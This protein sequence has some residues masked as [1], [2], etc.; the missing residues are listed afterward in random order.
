MCRDTN[1]IFVKSVIK[2]DEASYHEISFLHELR[3][4]TG[5]S[6][7]AR[8][9][10]EISCMKNFAN[11]MIKKNRFFIYLINIYFFIYSKVYIPFARVLTQKWN[12]WSFE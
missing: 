7:S 11:Y 10:F 12:V 6:I 3:L 4:K 5:M 9:K 2:N 8:Q 1:L